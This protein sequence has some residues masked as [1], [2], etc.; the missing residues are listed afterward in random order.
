[1]KNL[2]HSTS[3]YNMFRMNKHVFD[4]LHNVLVE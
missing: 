3:C 4:R 1:M 2:G